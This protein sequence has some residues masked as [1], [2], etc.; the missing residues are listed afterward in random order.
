MDPG[1]P[2]ALGKAQRLQPAR[3]VELAGPGARSASRANIWPKPAHRGRSTT[4][5]RGPV[6]GSVL[7]IILL[8]KYLDFCVIFGVRKT[9]N[10]PFNQP[11]IST[12]ASGLK[13]CCMSNPLKAVEK[14]VPQRISHYIHYHFQR[15]LFNLQMI[16]V[17]KDV[18]VDLVFL[19]ASPLCPWQFW[20]LI[21]LL[22]TVPASDTAVF[23]RCGR[24][25]CDQAH[26]A[27]VSLFCS[28]WSVKTSNLL[29]KHITLLNW[30]DL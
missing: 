18:H 26:P 25:S 27:L 10:C 11:G 13:T 8:C 19:G 2:R 12:W 4:S 14:P 3:A 7:F 9:R 6:G 20:L 5:W 29:D 15:R 17:F 16:F 30:I 21:E 24:S 28:C 1:F 22:Y 23:S